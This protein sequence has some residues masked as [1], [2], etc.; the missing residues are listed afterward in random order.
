MKH[1]DI[2]ELTSDIPWDLFELDEDEA[3]TKDAIVIA[4]ANFTG[5]EPAPCDLE[6]MRPYLG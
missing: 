6:E 2:V 5:T 3:L 1:L 4:E